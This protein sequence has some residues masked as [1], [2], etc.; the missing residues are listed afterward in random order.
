MLLVSGC[1]SR[2]CYVEDRCKQDIEVD[3]CFKG[4]SV[5]S[6]VQD[7]GAV[8]KDI[9]NSA[10]DK[11]LENRNIT[12]IKNSSI[13]IASFVNLDD[14][15]RRSHLGNVLSENMIHEMHLKG[16]L[17]VDYKTLQSATIKTRYTLVG[18]FTKYKNSTLVNAR[19]VDSKT[20]I[21]L[22][23]TQFLISQRVVRQIA[24]KGLFI[25]DF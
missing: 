17:V 4:S 15:D 24:P 7:G 12:N 23:S 8:I 20:K 25:P 5:D 13:A 1:S 10:I 6:S 9:V 11:L 22:S 2:S 16:Y 14:S 19:I 21:V 18:T 3:S